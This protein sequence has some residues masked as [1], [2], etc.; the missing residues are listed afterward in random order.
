MPGGLTHLISTGASFD[1]PMLNIGVYPARV[2]RWDL[3]KTS[4]LQLLI[5]LQKGYGCCMRTNHHPT[6]S[7]EKE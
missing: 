6:R 5:S 2:M 1:R 4:G 3:F 7:E